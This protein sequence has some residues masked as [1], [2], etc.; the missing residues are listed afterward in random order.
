VSKTTLTADTV[1]RLVPEIAMI[2]DPALRDAVVAIWLQLWERSEYEQLEQV[3]VSLKIP[4]PQLRHTQAVIRMALAVADVAADV[5]GTVVNR[6]V[7]IAGAMLM[8]VSKLV[9]YRPGAD[10]N[11]RTPLGNL[12][13]HGTATAT[14]ALDAGLP[15]EAVHI[16][17]AHSP[18][19]GKAPA[20]VEAHLLDWLDQLDIDMF[21][22]NLWKR[23]VIHLQP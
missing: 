8:D 15:L 9:E 2:S 1:A 10:D 21:G 14:L 4:Y 7:L 5:H 6:D 12:L 23:H 13:P 18:N 16:V 22:T 20:T 19:G 3:P 11:E 17:M